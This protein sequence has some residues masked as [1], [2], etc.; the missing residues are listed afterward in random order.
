MNYFI[1]S[2]RISGWVSQGFPQRTRSAQLSKMVRS[3]LQLCGTDFMRRLVLLYLRFPHSSMEERGPDSRPPHLNSSD[4]T[5]PRRSKKRTHVFEIYTSLTITWIP[6][7]VPPY[8]GCFPFNYP[9][10]DILSKL[11]C[12]QKIF[13]INAV[14]NIHLIV[15]WQILLCITCVAGVTECGERFSTFISQAF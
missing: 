12:Y 4:D 14:L 10:A 1:S 5:C 13:G 3:I 6:L 2:L 11:K 7:I 15:N 8:F 9:H